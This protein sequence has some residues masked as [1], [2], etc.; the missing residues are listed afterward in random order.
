MAV[1]LKVMWDMQKCE[2]LEDEV[3]LQISAHK[4]IRAILNYLHSGCDNVV[5]PPRKHVSVYRRIHR[6][7]DQRGHLKCE[8]FVGPGRD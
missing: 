2:Q 4:T 5:E 3:Q 1:N 6:R 8:R 7:D